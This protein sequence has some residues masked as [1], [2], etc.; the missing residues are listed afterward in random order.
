MKRNNKIPTIMDSVEPL[1]EEEQKEFNKKR[2]KEWFETN[3][4]SII[5]MAAFD[6]E[7]NVAFDVAFI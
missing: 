1:S 6:V 2:R 3:I 4:E 7:L 5:A